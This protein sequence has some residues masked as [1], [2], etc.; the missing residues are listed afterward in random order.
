MVVVLELRTSEHKADEFIKSSGFAMSHC[1]EA[2][3]FSRGIWILWQDNLDIEVVLNHKQFVHMKIAKSVQGPWFVGGNFNV[4]LYASEKRVGLSHRSGVCNL[5]CNWFHSNKLHDL[6]FKGPRFTWA[7]ANLFKR[8]DKVICNDA[9]FRTFTEGSVLHLP[10]LES[11]YRPVLVRFDH[12]ERRSHGPKPFCFLTALLT[13]K[14][15]ANF[16]ASN[17]NSTDPYMEAV[18][19][20]TIIVAQWSKECFGNIF[21]RKRRLLGRLAGIQKALEDHDSNSLLR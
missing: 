5:F 21:H 6:Y 2:T 3:C 1:I 17:W 7:R 14:D 12:I 4:I 16:A 15:F 13:N 19:N 10:K 18:W 8:L 11:D 20:F 9:W